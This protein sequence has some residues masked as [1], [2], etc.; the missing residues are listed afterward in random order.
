M[1]GADPADIFYYVTLYN[2][3]LVMPARPA[4]VTDADIIDGVYRWRAA[5]GAA[6]ASVLFSGTACSAAI[7]ASSIL[8]ERYGINVDLWSA[9]S[10][11]SLREDAMEVERWNRLHPAQPRRTSIIDRT[12]GSGSEPIVAV[13]DFMRIVSEQ[14]APYLPGRRFLALGTDGMGRSDTRE[15]LRRFFETDAEHVVVAV[16]TTLIGSHGITAATVEKAISDLG[17]DLD[18]DHGLTRD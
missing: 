2:E 12:L 13:S 16:L 17:I 15:A 11:K 14:I 18:A 5:E 1:Y 8:R 4:H 6:H 10:Y 3:N 7:E 9:T